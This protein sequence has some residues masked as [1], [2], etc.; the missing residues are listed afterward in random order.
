MCMGCNRIVR[1]I[2]PFGPTSIR[3]VLQE[4][5][6]SPVCIGSQRVATESMRARVVK[7][8][9][10]DA[11]SDPNRVAPRAA[12]LIEA[13]RSLG[14]SLETAIADLVDNSLSHGARTVR[15]VFDWDGRNSTVSISDDGCGMTE[16]ALVEAMRLGTHDPRTE[17]ATG[18]LGRFGLGLKTASFSQAKRL[19]VISRASDHQPAQRIWDLDFVS[20][21]DDWILRQ[22]ATKASMAC[23]EWALK[24]TSGTCVVW[25]CM[26]RLVGDVEPDNERAHQTFLDAADKVQAHL[27]MVFGDFLAGKHSVAIFMGNVRLQP[28]DPFIEGHAQRQALQPDNLT[29]KG[30][31]VRVQPYVLPHHSSLTKEEFAAAAGPEGWN[32]HQGFYIYRNRRLIVAGGWLTLGLTREEHHKLARI[33]IDLGNDADFD[34]KLD[35]RKSRASPPAELRDHLR[36]IARATR[37]RAQEVYRHRG[38]RIL[39]ADPVDGTSVWLA[40]AR[41]GK[42]V[43]RIN[44]DHPIVKALASDGNSGKAVAALLRL[45]EETVPRASIYIREAE[46]PQQQSA[47][48]EGTKDQ[49]IRQML[50]DLYLGLIESGRSHKQ[51]IVTVGGLQVARDRPH[52]VALLDTSPPLAPQID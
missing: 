52:L 45:I 47:P 35:V 44:R 32:A 22:D 6:Q 30:H 42:T 31:K 34:W 40:E 21:E 36:R 39:A 41:R 19:T 8:E 14:Y 5:V 24:Q 29:F 43:F 11:G 18:D 9:P 3:E 15:I 48:F 38:R 7:V 13:M 2:L 20:R 4:L 50:A 28:W 33:R 46:S 25:E 16:P 12:S 37:E 23:A 10:G 17:R 27:S 26:D 49:E 51:A 1:D